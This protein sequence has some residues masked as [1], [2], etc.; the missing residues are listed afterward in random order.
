MLMNPN[1]PA[2][3]GKIRESINN[4]QILQKD[5]TDDDV[6]TTV[7]ITKMQPFSS[8]L[9]DLLVRSKEKAEGK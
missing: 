6:P 5:Q 3:M 2:D 7:Y 1:I 8:R 4:C 9:V